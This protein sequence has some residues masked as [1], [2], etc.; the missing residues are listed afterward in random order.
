[1][2]CAL[3]CICVC[4]CIYTCVC[5]CIYDCM[6]IR[7]FAC[8]CV[9]V[10]HVW[11]LPLLHVHSL[12]DTTMT[13]LSR[14]E[15]GGG[16]LARRRR[17]NSYSM[18]AKRR[19]FYS[20]SLPFPPFPRSREVEGPSGRSSSRTGRPTTISIVLFPE[21]E[22]GEKLPD[23]RSPRPHS[24]FL[25]R[26]FFYFSFDCKPLFLSNIPLKIF[27]CTVHRARV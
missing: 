6:F 23:T 13:R 24:Q 26:V 8:A 17:P 16:A 22:P 2:Y 11:I 3:L 10:G 25:R 21:A 19:F 4:V 18:F 5:V 20:L 9:C 27:V 7:L 15:K 14:L 1:M 12:Y